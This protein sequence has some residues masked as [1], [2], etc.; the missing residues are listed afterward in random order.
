MPECEFRFYEELNDFLAPPRRKRSFFYR[1]DG[2]PAVKD[3]IEALGVPHT[4]V[5]L[6]LIDGESVPFAHRLR[7][8]ERV[9]VYPVFERLDIAPLTR[10]R[11]RPL[12]TPRFVA[13]VHLGTLAR[14]LRLLGFDTRY[15]NRAGDAELVR[16]S[17]GEKRTLLTRDV[18]L[19]KHKVLTH[20]HFVRATQPSEQLA[21][22]VRALDLAGRARPFTRCMVCNGRLRRIARARVAARL[23]PRVRDSALAIARCASCERLYWPGTHYARLTGLV[24]AHA[25]GKTAARAPRAYNAAIAMTEGTRMAA[26]TRTVHYA[27]VS[28]PSRPGE[29]AR[30]LEALRAANVNLLAFSGFPQGRSKAQI[31]LVTDDVEALKAVARR[32]K[33]KLSRVK[34]AFLVQGTDEIG[35]AVAPLATMGGAKINVIAADAIAAGDGRFGMIFW[36]APRDFNRAARLLGAA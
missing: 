30:V 8:G 12:R 20:A 19:L 13:D 14:H 5:D 29:A 15:S 7:G 32:E 34:R 28:A 10:L 23:P 36:V 6:V 4:E 21:E 3:A 31:D 26:S 25:R 22:I 35:A 9:A 17:V 11:P 16:Q 33:W 24:A 2:R 18:G 1:F 27:Y